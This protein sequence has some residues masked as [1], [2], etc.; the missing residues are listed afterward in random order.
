MSKVLFQIGQT[1]AL[2]LPPPWPKGPELSYLLGAESWHFR[3]RQIW[4]SGFLLEQFCPTLQSFV[5]DG[6]RRGEEQDGDVSRRSE[7]A[8]EEKMMKHF[9]NGRVTRCWV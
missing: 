5:C 7:V 8:G 1:G 3:F 2:Y 4:D 9:W 6:R